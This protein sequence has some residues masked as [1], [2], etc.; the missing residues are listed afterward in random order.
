MS[1][2]LSNIAT[3][4][5][6][7]QKWLSSRALQQSPFC[8]VPVIPPVSTLSNRVKKEF[9]SLFKPTFYPCSF[10]PATPTHRGCIQL[11][12]ARYPLHC[13]LKNGSDNE[14][15]LHCLRFL[16]P[17]RQVACALKNRQLSDLYV[18]IKSLLLPSR[19]LPLP[20]SGFDG[21]GVIRQWWRP[22]ERADYEAH[23]WCFRD[24]YR[25]F[26]VEALRKLV[27]TP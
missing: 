22:E 19:S 4:T 5:A 18:L 6:L 20:G 23:T 15:Q 3:N 17:S 2:S 21:D 7:Q 1:S 26:R 11:P 10:S 12:L 14:R 25:V 8:L 9:S 13:E 27:S 24:Q 16:R